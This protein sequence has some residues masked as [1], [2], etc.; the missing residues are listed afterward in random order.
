MKNLLKCQG[1]III[2]QK[3]IRLFVASKH[4]KLIGIDLSI[5][6]NTTTPQKINFIRKLVDNGATMFFIAEKQ[7]KTKNYFK[8]FFGFI[9]HN[10][11]I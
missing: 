10:R 6:T 3:L 4:Y 2:Q 9:N 1:T 8:H 7:K 5:Q 11:I